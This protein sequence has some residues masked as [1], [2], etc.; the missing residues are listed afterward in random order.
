MNGQR[1]GI[2]LSFYSTILGHSFPPEV[3]LIHVPRWLPGFQSSGLYYITDQKKKK[4][5]RGGTRVYLLAVVLHVL[6]NFPTYIL[7]ALICDVNHHIMYYFETY[8]WIHGYIVTISGLS[9]VADDTRRERIKLLASWSFIRQG[10]KKQVLL[11]RTL[12]LISQL[13]GIKKECYY[14]F[15]KK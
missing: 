15:R 11:F 10:E 5:M 3:Y 4:C 8:F 14:S 12:I 7:L 1:N 9:L 13:N 2:I 6:C